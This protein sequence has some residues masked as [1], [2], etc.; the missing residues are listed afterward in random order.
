MYD[1]I[2]IS[3]VSEK[4]K[5]PQTDMTSFAE[6]SIGLPMGAINLEDA[7]LLKIAN[8]SRQNFVTGQQQT[9]NFVNTFV[10]RG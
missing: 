6:T 7:D 5:A 3:E 2:K 4:E 9:W 8:L 1:N 10:K